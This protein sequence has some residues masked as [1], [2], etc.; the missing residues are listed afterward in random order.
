[1]KNNTRKIALFLIFIINCIFAYSHGGTL[2]DHSKIE[3]LSSFRIQGEIDLRIE[4]DISASVA[5]R[6]LNHEG[7][8]KIIVMEVLDEGE[9]KSNEGL[10]LY[11]L[12]TSPMWVDDGSWVKKN[13][14]FLIFLPNDMPVFDFEK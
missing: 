3:K 7:G 12:L 10:W 6:T 5:Y 11:V 1:M 2:Y 8:M 14:K 4:K 13:N 9:Y